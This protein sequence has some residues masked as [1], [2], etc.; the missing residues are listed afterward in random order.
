[1]GCIIISDQQIIIIN[2]LKIV[3]NVKEHIVIIGN[4]VIIKEH[5]KQMF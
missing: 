5:V 2:V 3:I 4:S 1:M